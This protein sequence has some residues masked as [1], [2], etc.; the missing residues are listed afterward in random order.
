LPL[1][2]PKNKKLWKH[3][4]SMKVNRIKNNNQ[5]ASDLEFKTAFAVLVNNKIY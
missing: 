3:V 1:L 5:S 4:G 2:P